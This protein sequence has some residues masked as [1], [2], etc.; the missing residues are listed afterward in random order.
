MKKPT[1][2]TKRNFEVTAH[3]DAYHRNA[4]DRR[5]CVR[6]HRRFVGDHARPQTS[7]GIPTTRLFVTPRFGRSME[8]S[9][10]CVRRPDGCVRR[11][12]DTDRFFPIKRSSISL[13]FFLCTPLGLTFTPELRF[14]KK[15]HSN[16]QKLKISLNCASSVKVSPHVKYVNGLSPKSQCFCEIL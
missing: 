8:S 2:L 5:R 1:K 15:T 4:F 12:N 7:C 14:S 10:G 9:I 6:D 16:G 11:P 3:D 13:Q